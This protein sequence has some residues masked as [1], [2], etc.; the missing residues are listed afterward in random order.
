[1]MENYENANFIQ[2]AVLKDNNFITRKITPYKGQLGGAIEVVVDPDGV[3]IQC[4]SRVFRKG[5]L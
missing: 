2:T 5:H 1:M 3:V 4:I